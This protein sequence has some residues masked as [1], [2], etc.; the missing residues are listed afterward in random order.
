MVATPFPHV[1]AWHF[2][3][4]IQ[5]CGNRNI[6]AADCVWCNEPCADSCSA[7]I[8]RHAWLSPWNKHIQLAESTRSL[9]CVC[10]DFPG[11]ML[12]ADLECLRWRISFHFSVPIQ[13]KHRAFYLEATLTA[14]RGENGRISTGIDSN[15][16]RLVYFWAR[17]PRKTMFFCFWPLLSGLNIPRIVSGFEFRFLLNHSFA[18]LKARFVSKR[19]RAVLI[20][21]CFRPSPQ[22]FGFSR[23]VSAGK[24][25]WRDLVTRAAAWPFD[26][27]FVGGPCFGL[28]CRFSIERAPTR[29]FHLPFDSFWANLTTHAKSEFSGFGSKKWYPPYIYKPGYLK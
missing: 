16:A 28:W 19:S 10:F 9:V 17:K 5:F 23:S 25:N 3:Q 4:V 20:A 29:L 12:C 21:R 15:F 7:V 2:A 18:F 26:E 1:L 22:K 6:F 13:T 14:F 8:L 27:V 24:G 11:R